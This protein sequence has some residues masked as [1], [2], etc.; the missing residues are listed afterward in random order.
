MLRST[1]LR[2]SNRF[3]HRRWASTQAKPALYAGKTRSWE[4]IVGLEVHAQINS[5]S[6]LFSVTPTS[7]N[8]P[9]NTK[10]SAFDAAFPGTLPWV[11]EECVSL[12]VKTV[13]ALSG[14]VQKLSSF[15]RKHYFYPDIPAGYQITQHSNPIGLGGCIELGDLDGLPYPLKIRLEQVQLEQDTGKSTHD[16]QPGASLID[17]N[18]AGTGLMEIVTLPDMRS[19]LEAG[20]MVRKLQALLRAVG[21]SDG[22]MEEGSMRC[23]VNVSIHEPGTPY[24]TRCELKNLG[25]VKVLMSAIDAEVQRQ[26]EVLESGGQILQE[27]RGYDAVQNQTFKLRSKETAPDYR[28]MPEPDLPII[29]LTDQY[30]EEALQHMPELPDTR[31]AR[32]I[33]TYKLSLESCNTLM[34]EPGIVEY[35]EEICKEHDPHKTLSWITSELFG[36]LS[37][38][39]ISFGENPVSHGQLGSIIGGIEKGLISGKIGKSVLNVMMEGDSRNALEIAKAKGWQQIDDESALEKLCLDLI[40]SNPGELQKVQQGNKRVFGWFVGQ[41]M[42]ETKGKANP[43][44]VNSIL[45]RHLG[46]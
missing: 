38:K 43:A 23:D 13:L 18:R 25:S 27:T 22:N 11:N 9:V 41:I 10:Y 30:I 24:G 6:K 3:V 28:Y 14:Q 39:G 29:R 4:A 44:L 26:I 20:L 5:Y 2:H 45:K 37:F 35:F 40:Q 7:F 36:L 21:S 16:I 46:L 12:A 31:R 33:D 1:C 17:L 42:K 8:E 15:E 34:A 32:L 19:S